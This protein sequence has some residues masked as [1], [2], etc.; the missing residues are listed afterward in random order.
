MRRTL[1]F[2]LLLLVADPD[3]VRGQAQSLPQPHGEIILT[4]TG[5]IEHKNSEAGAIFDRAMLEALGTQ[6]LRT[7]SDWTDGT[8]EFEGVPARAVMA[9]VGAR[10][11]TL[12]ASALNDYQVEIPISDFENYPV[13]FALKMDGH[14]LTV[15]DRGPIWI[16]YP[17]DDF[18]ELRNEKVNSRW[19]WQLSGLTVE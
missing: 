10:G 13:L 2:A 18:P 12:I 17:R 7:S 9:A 6:K 15:R 1:A 4:V 19:V 14:E 16:V 11:T 5:N 8:V 3:L